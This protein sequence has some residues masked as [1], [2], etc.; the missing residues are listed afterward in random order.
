[1]PILCHST[2]PRAARSDPHDAD[3]VRFAEE[4]SSPVTVILELSQ[5]AWRF[6]AAPPETG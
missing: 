3:R 1:V 2:L 5:I 6:A 4:Q